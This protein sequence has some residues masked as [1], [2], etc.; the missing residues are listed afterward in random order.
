VP[1]G[2]ARQ[3][4][5]DLLA[6]CLA[7]PACRGVTTWGISDAF[8]W[9]EGFFGVDGAPLPFDEQ[10]APKPAYAGM[11]DAMLEACGADCDLG[12]TIDPIP[13]PA[14][15][16][17]CETAADCG[18]DACL[19]GTACDASV[20]TAGTPVICDDGD[21][22]TID[23]CDAVAGCVAEPV[24]GIAAV[25]CTCE[26]DPPEACAG[27]TIPDYVARREAKACELAGR[28][29]GPSSTRAQHLLKRAAGRFRAR[30]ARPARPCGEAT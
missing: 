23:R 27:E 15:P 11:R 30:R 18:S 17:C 10:F 3:T 14:A 26:R 1:P 6:A 2:R 16:G 29:A 25:T 12:C 9:I 21:P 28:A 8:T 5:H 19:T 13:V 22:C 24:A 20:C 7:A 4:Y